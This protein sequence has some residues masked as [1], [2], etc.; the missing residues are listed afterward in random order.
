MPTVQIDTTKP[1][2]V[3]L[4]FHSPHA[5]AYRLW[6][7]HPDDAK[8]TILATGT[9][10]EPSNPSK[11]TH[12]VNALPSGSEL[13]YLAWL[14]GNGNTP[15]RIEITLVQ[16]GLPLPGGTFVEEGSTDAEGFAQEKNTISLAG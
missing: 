2:A 11:H 3:V 6:Y 4:T 9:D 8:Y 12:M 13:V 5:V 7:K 14:S 1:L 16:N 15:Y 10:S